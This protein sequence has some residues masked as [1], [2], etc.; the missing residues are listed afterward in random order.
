MIGTS[1]TSN[2]LAFSMRAS[3]RQAWGDKPVLTLNAR[4]KWLRVRLHRP[5]ISMIDKGLCSISSLAWR[6]RAGVSAP[7]ACEVLQI[8]RGLMATLLFNEESLAPRT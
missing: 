1:V 5:A 6:R 3:R 8:V 4:E 7:G 2:R